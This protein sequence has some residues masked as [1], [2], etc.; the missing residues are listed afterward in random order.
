MPVFKWG[1]IIMVSILIG[2]LV[3]QIVPKLVANF[4][5]GNSEHYDGSFLTAR[6]VTLTSTIISTITTAIGLW[7]MSVKND[8]SAQSFF[9]FVLMMVGLPIVIYGIWMFLTK[10]ASFKHS[11][12]QKASNGVLATTLVVFILVVFFAS[13][14]TSVMGLGGRQAFVTHVITQ[15]DDLTL[16]AID[17]S[18]FRNAEKELYNGL[19][20][21]EE[22]WYNIAEEEARTG[23]YT[24]SSGKGPLYRYV[25]GFGA[26]FGTVANILQQ[27]KVLETNNELLTLVEDVETLKDEISTKDY[28]LVFED[29]S[30]YEQKVRDLYERLNT[31]S[32]NSRLRGAQTI[33]DNL[34]AYNPE[35]KVDNGA[36]G[37]QQQEMMTYFKSPMAESQSS[38]GVLLDSAMDMRP[39]RVRYETVSMLNGVFIY[40]ATIKE[41]W[42]ISV[43][44]DS[45]PLFLFLWVLVF[46]DEIYL[47]RA[48]KPIKESDSD[49][50]NP[51]PLTVS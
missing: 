31:I 28:S 43:L 5:S 51:T 41:F 32:S 24:G 48:V 25:R 2:Y 17:V 37:K 29:R 21:Q 39:D 30:V 46:K 22:H 15:L 36:I 44:F 33:L 27:G 11:D 47:K 42:A 3:M 18:D 4:D 16:K 40:A 10:I 35:T 9:T 12:R 1:G 7:H 49:D 50:D 14:T 13:T 6:M 38:L 8:A 45:A 34:L 23:K 26:T 19:K 20:G